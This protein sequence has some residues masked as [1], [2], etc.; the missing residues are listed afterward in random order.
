M[1]IVSVGYTNEAEWRALRHLNVGGS[2]TAALFDEHPRI[3]R[4]E[5][6][7]RKAGNV[8]E[9]D[10]SDNKRVEVGSVIEPAIATLVT[11]M[12]GWNVKKVRRYLRKSLALFNGNEVGIGGSPDFGIEA[13]ERGPGVLEIKNTDWLVFRNWQDGE[14]PLQYELQ[15]QHYLH[16]MQREW[17]A[18]AV[19]VGGNDL[20]VFIRD[21]RPNIGRMIE[22]KA[23]EFWSS[24]IRGEPPKPDF[25][26]DA[27]TIGQLYGTSKPGTV[28]DLSHDNRLHELIA[29]YQRGGA[30]EKQGEQIKTASKAE[31]L[32]KIGDN[33]IVYCGDWRINAK[34]VAAK[35][36]AYD[37]DAY[38]DFRMFPNSKP[39]DISA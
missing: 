10:L 26:F 11:K 25:A 3:T 15:L 16:L 34:Q 9:P 28:I 18:I 22:K 21:G 6:W 33:E 37:R 5:L 4:F 39:K 12:H 20:R 38:R 27:E 30:L 31:M 24:M 7:H 19:L 23:L 14:P 1:T 29:E 13:H 2:E 36:I 32:E 35:H 17:G 8:P